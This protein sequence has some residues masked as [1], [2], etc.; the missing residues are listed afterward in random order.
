[1]KL[2][3]NSA[4]LLRSILADSSEEDPK[5]AA[6]LCTM[7]TDHYAAALVFWPRRES[8]KNIGEEGWRRTMWPKLD[9]VPMSYVG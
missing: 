5:D 9:S 1:M 6:L 7:H 2:G 3:V 8:N 4:L